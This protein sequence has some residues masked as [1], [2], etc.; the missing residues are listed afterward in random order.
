MLWR[1]DT[2]AARIALTAILGLLLFQPINFA[3][4]YFERTAEGGDALTD[5]VAMVTQI[6]ATVTQAVDS[7]PPNERARVLADIRGPLKVR[8]SVMPP[9]G[10]PAGSLGV[11]ELLRHH[12]EIEFGHHQ[13][14]ILVR[15][16]VPANGAGAAGEPVNAVEVRLAD[17]SWLVF[18][19]PP[20]FLVHFSLVRLAVRLGFL[21]LVIG[22][23]SAI[24]ARRLARPIADFAA[25]AERLG[26]DTGAP[27]LAERGP[28]ELRAATRAFNR[29]Q[30]RLRRFV[31][32]RTQMLAAMSHD[33][34]TP[35]TRLRL[36]TEFIEDPELQRKVLA[37]LDEMSA[38]V[39]STLA[40]A[41][42]DGESE[43]RVQVDLG[44][45]V[46]GVCEDATDGGS[47]VTFT[48]PRGVDVSCRPKALRRAV[49]NLIE[50]AVK[51]GGSARVAVIP[52]RERVVIAVED[53]G[54][55]IPTEELEKVFAPFYRVDRSRNRDTGGVGLGL[56]VAR[57][58][59]RG[60]GGDV[61]LA[62][63]AE[64]G[65]SA[66]LELPV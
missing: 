23:L 9:A 2:I 59:A 58:V 10:A 38:M 42:G 29:M 24:A 50:N 11:A 12:L 34:R 19:A 16:R 53:D 25:A 63:R 61:T 27:P 52:E 47:A 4:L 40:F 60:H 30:E 18:S 1:P 21:T 15:A 26:V 54:P 7:V 65:L 57:T 20:G 66:R 33:L 51:Y 13:R 31:A 36:R 3:L 56:A 32:D 48:G 14:E 22:V 46:E 8:I 28:R 37:D 43:P 5:K 39:E 62:N 45:L 41:R 17:G 55:G 35:L 64:G 49:A 44:L 6:I